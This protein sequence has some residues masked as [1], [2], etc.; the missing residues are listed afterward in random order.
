MKSLR[1]RDILK[2]NSKRAQ[3]LIEYSL[4]I[5]VL[6]L[7]LAFS[8]RELLQDSQEDSPDNLI[9]QATTTSFGDRERFGTVGRPYP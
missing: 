8:L 2:R 5:L 6:I 3:T 7:P 4:L 1:N 9:Y